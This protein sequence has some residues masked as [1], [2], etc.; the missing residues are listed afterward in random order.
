MRGREGGREDFSPYTFAAPGLA[1]STADA[2][3]LQDSSKR[4]IENELFGGPL[5]YTIYSYGTTVGLVYSLI[6]P[7]IMATY[8]GGVRALIL[9][10][11]M[12]KG[13]A[14]ILRKQ[15]EAHGGSVVS[16][17]EPSVTTCTHLLVGKNVRRSRLPILLG[18]E[19]VPGDVRVVRAD[20]LSSCLIRGEYVSEAVPL[21]TTP[22]TTPITGPQKG[23]EE[24][25]EGVR[26]K[27][28][29]GRKDQESGAER[30][31]VCVCVCVSPLQVSTAVSHA[32]P[33]IFTKMV[34]TNQEQTAIS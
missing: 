1:E 6:Y 21:Q 3:Y 29:C 19:E 13:C 28:G 8:L 24:G 14:S 18:V 5:Y 32:V 2:G 10:K 15:L 12:G 9:E 25:K 26:R 4:G 11:G 20:W 30:V 16:S 7:G 31:S 17:L 34:R 23:G 33:Y 22:S 27:Q